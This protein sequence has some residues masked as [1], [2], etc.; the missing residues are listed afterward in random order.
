MQKPAARERGISYGFLRIQNSRIPSIHSEEFYTEILR[1]CA[2]LY[3]SKDHLFI[4]YA[5]EDSQLAKWLQLKLTAEGYKVWCDQIKLLG[6]ESYPTDIDRAIKE[7]T[8]RV[9]GLLSKHSLSKPN[10][11]KERTLALRI[12]ENLKNDFLIPL[13]VDGLLPSQLDWMTSDLTFIP[14][15][16]SWAEGFGKLLKKLNSIN[17]PKSSVSGRNIVTQWFNLM[18]APVSREERLWS[19]IFNIYEI[20]KVLYRYRIEDKNTILGINY[21]WSFYRESPNILWAFDPPDNKWQ[22]PVSELA[23]VTWLTTEY[24][25]NIKMTNVLIFLLRNCIRLACFRKGL[26][27]SE[28]NRKLF[29]P[30]GLIDRNKLFFMNYTCKKT[31]IKIIGQRNFRSGAGSIETINY[32]LSPVFKLLIDGINNPVILLATS[33]YITDLSGRQL[34][35]IKNNNRRKKICKSWWNHQ[36]LSRQIALVSWLS[37]GQDMWNIAHTNS[38]DFIASAIPKQF[39]SLYGITEIKLKGDSYDDDSG[40]LEDDPGN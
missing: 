5:S 1:S 34:E 23:A 32:H 33:L 28:D 8:F 24:Y 2:I 13:N 18:D 19:N 39:K 12:A 25:S 37:N 16:K 22:I 17:A 35:G 6:G 11:L 30:E 38:G 26:K 31:F 21:E 14:F 40:I 3:K 10:P 29:F 7:G 4:S 15:N 27:M 20:P 36:W 9:L